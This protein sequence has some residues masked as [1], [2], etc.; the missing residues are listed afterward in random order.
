MKTSLDIPDNELREVMKY[1]KAKTKR[2][3]I[4]T[5]VSDYNHRQRLASLVGYFGTFDTL[6]TNEEVEALEDKEQSPHR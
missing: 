2:E 1:T 6:M 3:A 4:L 5:A